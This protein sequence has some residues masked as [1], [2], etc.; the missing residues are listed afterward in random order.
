MIKLHTTYEGYRHVYDYELNMN[1]TYFIRKAKV[2]YHYRVIKESWYNVLFVLCQEGQ[3]DRKLEAMQTHQSQ[4]YTVIGRHHGALSLNAMILERMRTFLP[5]KWILSSS[6][7]SRSTASV[8]S[9]SQ[10]PVAAQ[11][12]LPPITGSQPSYIARVEGQTAFKNPYGFLPGE[13]Y[14]LL[15][16]EAARSS[17]YFVCFCYFLIF[18]WVNRVSLSLSLSINLSL[19]LIFF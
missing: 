13:L 18:Y 4:V 19:C 9:S 10:V 5:S 14:G 17:L 2:H 16:F 12:Q 15:P 1:S 7:N 8:T 3:S 11:Q 6:S